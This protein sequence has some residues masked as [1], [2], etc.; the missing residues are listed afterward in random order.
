[1]ASLTLA[2][3]A[4]RLYLDRGTITH[5]WM[6]EAEEA[7]YHDFAPS[8]SPAAAGNA[9]SSPSVVLVVVV[10][11]SSECKL[12]AERYISTWY[13]VVLMRQILSEDFDSRLI[14]TMVGA[15]AE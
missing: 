10:V 3:Q 12:E 13:A 14:P 11:A 5:S 1:M 8:Q 2:S 6:C 15:E 9:A 4:R 7:L